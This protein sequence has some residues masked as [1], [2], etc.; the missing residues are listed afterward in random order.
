M[1]Q[2]KRNPFLVVPACPYG[3]PASAR[4]LWHGPRLIEASAA[5]SEALTFLVAAFNLPF[6]ETPSLLDV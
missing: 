1:I 2:L 3:N 5:N 6:L 4:F